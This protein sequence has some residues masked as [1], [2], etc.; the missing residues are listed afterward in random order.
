MSGSSAKTFLVCVAIKFVVKPHHR[1]WSKWIF[2]RCSSSNNPAIDHMACVDL[3]AALHVCEHTSLVSWLAVFPENRHRQSVSYSFY[4]ICI[5]GS[6]AIPICPGVQSLLSSLFSPLQ[7][8]PPALF[9]WRNQFSSLFS[10][11]FFQFCLTHSALLHHLW[12]ANC[13]PNGLLYIFVPALR[14]RIS[15]AITRSPFRLS[16]DYETENTW[17][18]AFNQKRTF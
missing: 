2:S 14:I 11:L 9:E 15:W 4:E 18:E 16:G 12:V 5:V 1:F 7:A 6:W 13:N 8:F 3:C 10:S 17:E